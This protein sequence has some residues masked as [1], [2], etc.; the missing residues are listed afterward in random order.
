MRSH[1]TGVDNQHSR[2]VIMWGDREKPKWIKHHR[3][4]RPKDKNQIGQNPQKRKYSNTPTFKV[5]DPIS[6]HVIT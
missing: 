1:D 5:Y 2:H 3:R 6:V 4:K